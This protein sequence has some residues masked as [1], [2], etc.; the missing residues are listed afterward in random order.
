[1]VNEIANRVPLTESGNLDIFDSRP[2]EY[3]P[4]VREN[5]RGALKPAF[6]PLDER[7]W[8]IEN[9]EEFL[10]KRQQLIA[11]GISDYLDGLVEDSV[12]RPTT[13]QSMI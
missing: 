1:M 10:A 8:K 9:Y 11:E 6:I 4:T 7:L 5:H 12:L 13:D 3:L 2:T